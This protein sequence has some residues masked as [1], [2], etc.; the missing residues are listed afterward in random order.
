MQT[1]RVLWKNG[2]FLT[3]QHLQQAERYWESRHRVGSPT[4]YGVLEQS[5][6]SGVLAQKK[7]S[8]Q[9]CLAVM[10]DGTP[11][12]IGRDS[13]TNRTGDD[14]PPPLQAVELGSGRARLAV[15]LTLPERVP[16]GRYVEESLEVDDLFVPT[17]RRT[18]VVGRKNLQFRVTGQPLDGLIS[19][20][21]AEVERDA[22]GQLV[23]CEDYVPP[24]LVLSGSAY[25]ARLIER[26]LLRAEARLRDRLRLKDRS[27]EL[28][29][30]LILL[31]QVEVLRHFKDPVIYASTHPARLFQEL[32]RLAGGLSL[33]SLTPPSLPSYSHDN[34]YGCFSALEQQILMLLG[35]AVPARVDAFALRVRQGFEQNVIWDGTVPKARPNPGEVVYLVLSG[36]LDFQR[37][38]REIPSRARLGGT[39]ALEH[40]L[41]ESWPG[42]RLIPEP[43]PEALRGRSRGA[44]IAFF[45]LPTAEYPRRRTGDQD[46]D[47]AYE[48]WTEI[49]EH[50]RVSLYIPFEILRGILPQA[51]LVYVREE[52]PV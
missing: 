36:D 47:R 48:L 1:A 3:P 26:L 28:G 11:I 33:L 50:G 27:E 21:I 44:S 8:L 31:Q 19:L 6:D 38:V 25:F 24:C 43:T 42:L 20:K 5:L 39:K 22:A 15:F 46:N 2:T 35:L 10:P 30:L 52:K 17:N 37:I 49:V 9:R 40:A 13:L 7:L 18:V 29:A 16:D 51:E 34:L 4:S 45:R 12:D 32:L 23:L 14:A 41:T